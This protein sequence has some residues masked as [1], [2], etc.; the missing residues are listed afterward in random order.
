[1]DKLL[2]RL[3]AIIFF[4]SMHGVIQAAV[5]Q[6]SPLSVQLSQQ[7]PISLLRLT[8]LSDSTALVQCDLMHWSQHQSVDQY[9]SANDILITPP[10]FKLPGHKTQIIRLG[11]KHPQNTLAQDTYR[12]FIREIPREIKT[13]E[14]KGVNFLLNLSLPIF[15]QPVVS[16]EQFIWSGHWLDT[17]HLKIQLHNL[18]NVTLFTNQWQLFTSDHAALIEKH[19]TFRYILPH[20]QYSWTLALKHS[21]IPMEVQAF[22]NAQTRTKPLQIF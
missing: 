6:V 10:L 4:S 9:R 1:M 5:L 16:K 8:N 13:D 19:K 17:R 12:I 15:V 21:S 20:Q 18:G 14:Q 11:L 7:Q 2:V 3:F 22:I